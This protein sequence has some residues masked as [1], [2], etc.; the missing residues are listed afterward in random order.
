MSPS[1]KGSGSARPTRGADIA[2]E[3]ERQTGV[4][5]TAF[6]KVAQNPKLSLPPYLP[7]GKGAEGFLF[8]ETY[9]FVKQ[10]I[11]AQKIVKEMLGQFDTEATKLDL[12][13]GAKKL[14]T[15]RTRS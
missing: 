5:G 13:G 3:V 2:S 9:Q 7:A 11:D 12:V 4:A 8:P 15:R 1:P 6:S 14:A 10:G